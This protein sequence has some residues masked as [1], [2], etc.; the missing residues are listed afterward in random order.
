MTTPKLDRRSL[1]ASALAASALAALPRAARARELLRMSTLGP[2]SSPNLV[3]TTFANIINRELPDFEIQV[4]ATG[5]ATRHVLD[6]A[7]GDTAFCMSSPAL[8][9]L[10]AGQRAMFEKI[11]EAPELA[12]KLR[13]MLN[14]P[15]GVYHIAVYESSGITA[16]DQVRGKRVFLGPPGSAAFTTMSQFLTA[17]TG[18]VEGTDYEAV[19][20]GWD[21]AAASFQDGNLDVYCNPTNAPSPVFTQIAVT[22]PIRFLGIPEA[23]LESE[24]VK[25]IAN[26]PG[27]GLGILPAGIY[28]ENQ[29]NE[30]DVT[31]LRVTVGIITNEAADEEMI[32][33]MTKTFFEGVAEMAGT[34]PWLNAITPQGAVADLNM[35]LHPGALRALEEMGVEIPDVGRS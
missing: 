7:K 22:N 5:A 26:R 8:H 21:A 10:L 34:A 23:S 30:G 24:A 13:A 1:L 18:L 16:L 31:T 2:G 35:P 27:F 12:K 19:K 28:G 17:V 29:Q 15:M 4:N 3:M 6:V 9:A 20:L 11:D 14:F 32:Y 25:A 33:A